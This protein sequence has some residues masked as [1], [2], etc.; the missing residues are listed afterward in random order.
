MSNIGSVYIHV[1][2]ISGTES[3][4]ATSGYGAIAVSVPEIDAITQ[5]T[6]GASSNQLPVP[7]IAGLSLGT[8]GVGGASIPAPDA[9]AFGLSTAGQGAVSISK[10]KI[11]ALGGDGTLGTG[12][13]KISIPSIIASELIANT[14]G[15]SSILIPI[16]IIKGSELYDALVC[17]VMG[18][19]AGMP[20]TEYTNYDFTGFAK[21]GETY[22]AL[23]RDGNI[24]RL[25]GDTDITESIDAV[26]ETGQDDMGTTHSKR[27]MGLV[28]GLKSDG[29]LQ[30]R[31]NRV[32]GYG[33]Y[34]SIETTESDV[35]ETRKIRSEKVPLSRTIG[36]EFSNVDGAD[37]MV[38]SL[39]LDVRLSP[40]RSGGS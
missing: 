21:L 27:L 1:P 6:W 2:T 9:I 5:W 20:L 13:A 37:F 29:E 7:E 18:L 39:E 22:L 33:E 32:D 23:S 40:R 35:I 14:S 25:G 16:P 12:R 30:Y 4:D 28:A 10:P 36:I 31:A 8:S 15:T 11:V 24:Y 38:D 17:L 34:I 3:T 19:D 26:F